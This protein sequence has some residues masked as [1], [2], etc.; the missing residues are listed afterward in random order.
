[1][2][3]SIG[4]FLR[5]IRLDH[6]EML[7]TMAERLDVSSAFLSAVENGK[8]KMPEAWY[9]KL[10]TLYS[11]TSKDMDALRRAVLESADT[12]ELNL[13]NATKDNRDLAISFARSFDELDEETS[14]KIFALL[15]HGGKE[16][17]DE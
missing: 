8:K 9:Q 7:K 13:K 12:V 5:R 14:R 2:L 11:F 16:D 15:K 10:S 17:Q 3:T 6:G 1:M 4:R